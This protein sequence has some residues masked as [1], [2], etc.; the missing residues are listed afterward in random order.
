MA[1]RSMLLSWMLYVGRIVCNTVHKRDR[2]CWKKKKHPPA[3]G[4][5]TEDVLEMEMTMR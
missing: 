4:I 1:R 2:V 3:S 5:D